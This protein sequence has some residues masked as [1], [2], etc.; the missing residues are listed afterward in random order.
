[1]TLPRERWKGRG[2]VLNP[3]NRY[4]RLHHQ[5]IDDGWNS[6]DADPDPDFPP[7][8]LRTEV[9]PDASRSVI[10]YNQS[11]DISFDRSINPYRGC[12]HGCAYCYARPSHAWLGLSPGLD[13]ESKLFAKPDLADLLV[14]EL[15]AKNYR[16][17]P[18][19]VGVIT[20]AY[21]PVER[22][23][24]LTRAVLEVLSDF[25]HPAV[26]ITKSALVLRDVDILASMAARGLVSV[27]ISITSL[28]ADLSRRLEPRASHPQRR[29][30]AI[31]GLAAAGIPVGVN[32]APII[33]GLTDSE[34]ERILS[35]AAA[36]GA[37]FANWI[38]LRLPLELKEL[39]TAWLEEHAPA[40]ARHVLSLVRDIRGGALNDARFGNRMSGQGAYADAIRQR[41][42]R[43]CA[44]LGLARD[45]PD[46]D[47]RRFCPPPQAGDQM[48]L[49]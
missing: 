43:Q 8:R 9:L 45:L 21:Q 2:A 27:T 23:L 1:M 42:I 40:R 49:F 5:A 3:A 22:R 46:Y 15:R 47:C 29:L 20:D 10:S 38:L 11:P 18:M 44:K 16:P 25:H 34:S 32:V 24:R 13:F 4:D 19:A 37:S 28:D 17:A 36:A 33:P 6:L 39:F 26:L 12:E 31:A 35:A 14:R 41:V 48:M 30:D 7:P